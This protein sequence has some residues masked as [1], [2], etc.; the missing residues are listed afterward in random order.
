MCLSMVSSLLVSVPAPRGVCVYR[1]KCRMKCLD[2][3]HARNEGSGERAGEDVPVVCSARR[4]PGTSVGGSCMCLFLKRN[5]TFV[6]GV[7]RSTLAG[8]L[9]VHTQL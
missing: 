1:M 3:P 8:T 7:A 9:G 5:M 4:S 2:A 6:F